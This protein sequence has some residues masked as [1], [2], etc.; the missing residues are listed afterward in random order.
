LALLL[1]RVGTGTGTTADTSH[2]VTAKIKAAED[3]FGVSFTEAERTQMSASFEEPNAALK[4]LRDFE[5]PNSLSPALTFD[6]RLRGVKYPAQK[7]RVNLRS[8]A[9]PLPASDTDIAFSSIIDLGIW[10]KNGQ[11]TS[12]RLTQIYLARI[13]KYNP[14]LEA[15]ITVTKDLALSQARAA[16][17]EIAAGNYKGPLHGIPY[18][19]KDL[20]DT[21]GIKTTYGAAPFKDPRS[22]CRCDVNHEATRSGRRS[23]WQDLSWGPRLWRHLVWR[24]DAQPL[25]HTRRLIGFKR[26]VMLDCRS[27]SVRFRAWHRN[28]R[29]YHFTLYALRNN[30]SAAHIWARQPR[31]RYGVMLVY[32]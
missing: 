9:K 30:G 13:E 32:G 19:A 11:L 8:R 17:A 15:Y 14:K 10:I 4:A 29:F 23:S 1:A 31:W 16:D 3:L 26:R 27:G 5:K 28:T 21:D 20:L 12:L 24:R 25:E 2:D 18:G 7:N 22:R 6:P